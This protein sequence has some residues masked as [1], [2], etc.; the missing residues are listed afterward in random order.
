M[1]DRMLARNCNG[2][3]GANCCRLLQNCVANFGFNLFD[4][5]NCLFLI[6][7]VKKEVNIGSRSNNFVVVSTEGSFRSV[8]FF[9][10]G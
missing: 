1:S 4:F 9:G 3:L 2:I 5:F 6:Q 7:A 10:N 8:V